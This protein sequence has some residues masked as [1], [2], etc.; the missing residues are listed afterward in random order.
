MKSTFEITLPTHNSSLGIRT[1]L[2]IMSRRPVFGWTNI[3]LVI[4]LALNMKR[5]RFWGVC[6][7]LLVG[8]LHLSRCQLSLPFFARPRARGSG[9]KHVA[10]LPCGKSRTQNP[11]MEENLTS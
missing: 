7:Y 4:F 10:V 1:N 11:N 3:P 2:I 8:P 9:P 6:V 5:R